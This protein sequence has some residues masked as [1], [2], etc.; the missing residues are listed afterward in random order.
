M[1]QNDID[2]STSTGTTFSDISKITSIDENDFSIALLAE[3]NRHL[4]S[5]LCTLSNL[6]CKKQEE[7]KELKLAT[8][9]ISPLSKLQSTSSTSSHSYPRKIQNFLQVLR[10]LSKFSLSSSTDDDVLTEFVKYLKSTYPQVLIVDSDSTS[11]LTSGTEE[12]IKKVLN[13]GIVSKYSEI[14]FVLKTPSRYSLL[15]YNTKDMSF[16]HH[17]LNEEDNEEAAEQMV[18]RL[19]HYVDVERLLHVSNT[20]STQYTESSLYT[21]ENII[22]IIWN[23]LDERLDK[24]LSL[25]EFE[26]LPSYPDELNVAVTNNYVVAKI[27]NLIQLSNTSDNKSDF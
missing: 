12:D 24:P 14:L 16:Y 15:V 25:D 18:L 5:E 23:E 20:A 2:S 7:I 6:L 3:K 9:A 22:K 19:R 8:K 1:L 27:N 17:C 13:P 4:H 11:L 10:N 26:K 21:I